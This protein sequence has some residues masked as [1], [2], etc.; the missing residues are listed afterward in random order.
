MTRGVIL[1]D[2]DGTFLDGDEHPALSREAFARLA[3]DWRVIWVTSRTAEEIAEAVIYLC[4]DAALFIT[5][6]SLVMDG[7]IVAE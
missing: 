2:L 3:R 5:G 1:S 7:G 6:H 4:S